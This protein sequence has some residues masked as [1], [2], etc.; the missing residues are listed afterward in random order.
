VWGFSLYEHGLD[1]V[2]RPQD[3]FVFGEGGQRRV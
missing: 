1:G 2:W 3:D